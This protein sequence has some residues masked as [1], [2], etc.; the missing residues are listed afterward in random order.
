[1]EN[2]LLLLNKIKIIHMSIYFYVLQSHVTTN[3]RKCM[4][5]AGPVRPV[6][7]LMAFESLDGERLW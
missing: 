3:L 2:A 1:M 5:V 4:E 6:P 7:E